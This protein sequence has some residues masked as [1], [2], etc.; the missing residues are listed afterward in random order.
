MT[1]YDCFNSKFHIVRDEF[2]CISHFYKNTIKDE[3]HIDDITWNDLDMN[4]T[5]TKMNRTFSNP[6]Q[7]C[8]YNMLRILQFDEDELKRRNRMIEFLQHNKEQREKIQSLLYFMG[9]EESYAPFTAAI[10]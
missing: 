3:F 10:V 8:L 4:R 1:I 5:Y 2:N 6:G 9:K 7:Q